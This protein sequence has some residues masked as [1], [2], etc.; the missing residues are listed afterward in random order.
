MRVEREKMAKRKSDKLSMCRGSSDKKSAA[1]VRSDDGDHGDYQKR[2][3]RRRA[4]SGPS[5]ERQHFS[6]CVSPT[7]S[8]TDESASD[9]FSEPDPDSS[10]EWLPSGP[11]RSSRASSTDAPE[12]RKRDRASSRDPTPVGSAKKGRAS[13]RDPTAVG[14]AKKGRA[15]IGG[16]GQHSGWHQ[17][18]N[19]QPNQ[20][21]FTATPG[22][23]GAAAE[24]DSDL[25]ADF[26][27]LFLT[28]ELLQHIVD[29]TNLYASQYIRAQPDSLPYSRVNAWKPVSVPELKTFFGLSFLTGYVKKPSLELYWSV[30]EVDAT[31]Y[32]SRTMSRNR[33]QMIWKFLHYNNNNESQDATDKMYKVRPVLNYIVEKCK[34]LYQPAQNIC[35]D[36]GMMQ[37]RGRPS[38]RVYTPQKPVKY[39]I[40]SYILCDSAT[41]YCFNMHPYVGTASTLPDTIFALLDRLQGHGYTLFMDNFYNSGALSERLLGAQTNL[42]ATLRKNMG[43]PKM[44]TTCHQDK[45]QKGHKEQVPHFKPEC[46]IPYNWSMNGVDKLDQ[47]I[48]YYPFI[49]RS[50]NWSK[51]FVTYLFQLCM[52]NAHVLYRAKNPE[53]CKTLLEFMRR[54]VKSWTAKQFVGEQVEEVE[55]EVGKQVEEVEVGKQVK[56]EEEVGKQVMEE[57]EEVGKQV[58]E[59]EV[60]KQVKEEEVGKQVKEEEVKV[61]ELEV[62]VAG[63]CFTAY[64]TKLNYSVEH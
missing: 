36:E 11:G 4:F 42:C 58:D 56:E 47:N 59:V 64:H 25:P 39:G 9:E 54:V 62:E 8:S 7:A 22:P 28:N 53:E 44:V 57:E 41:G 3:L 52:F 63:K 33:F 29:Q 16:C 32:F 2:Q 12:R 40:K 14:S 23:R 49:R 60:G 20:I 43:G 31:P 50:L 35:I 26:L 19:W 30:D 18:E 38:F 24:L 5:G 34:E 48:A 6:R 15:S 45:M 17:V 21:P 27:E 61:E 55:V 13:S 51:K 37:W 1:V 10:D 46:V